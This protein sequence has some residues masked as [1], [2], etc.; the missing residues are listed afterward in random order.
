MPV[1]RITGG[2]LSVEGTTGGPVDPDFG[3]PTP[4]NLPD[5]PVDP[6]FGIPLPPV[7]IWPTPPGIS[8]GPIIPPTYPVDPGYGQGHPRLPHVDGGLPTPPGPVEGGPPIS[9]GHPDAGLPIPPGHVGGGPMP[10]SR[11]ADPGYG[12]GRPLPPHMWPS[13]PVTTWPPP[14][15][16]YPALPI[17]LPPG[18]ASGGPVP[19]GQPVDPGYGI[20]MPPGSVWP[21][22]PGIGGKV[23]ALVWIPG[24]G[25]RWVVI[26]PS[27]EINA[28]PADPSEPE[29]KA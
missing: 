25:Y 16:V 12:Q 5:G 13:P 20:E 1:V 29:P 27:L 4:P 26:D 7:T 15:P 10:P 18:H 28:G 2:A 21:P 8:G 14:Q 24:Y 9:P 6:G 3:Q 23:I 17:Y 22:L 19:P 11:P